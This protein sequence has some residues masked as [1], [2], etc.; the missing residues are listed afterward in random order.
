MGSDGFVVTSHGYKKKV[1]KLDLTF[2]DHE[3]AFKSKTT[4]EVIR[5]LLVFHLCSIG[6]IVDNNEKV[7]AKNTKLI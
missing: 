3:A 2:L 4:W 7:G 1:D 6:P 5:G